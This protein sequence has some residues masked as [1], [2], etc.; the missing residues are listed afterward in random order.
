MMEIEHFCNPNNKDHPKFENVADVVL[1]LLDRPRQDGR[2]IPVEM[3]MRDAVAQGVINNETLAYFMAR[4]QLFMLK[5]GVKREK[6]RFRQHKSNEMA[7]YAQDC[8][9]AEIQSSYGWIECVG[10]ADRSAYDLEVHTKASKRDLSARE[11]FKTPQIVNRPAAKFNNKAVKKT[12]G[13]TQGP[14]RKFF[15]TAT[16]EDLE[17]LMKQQQ[18]NGVAV[19]TVPSGETYELTPDLVSIT[20]EQKKITGIKYIPSVIEP[21]FGLGRIMYS[22]LEHAYTERKGK[23]QKGSDKAESYL[24]LAPAVAPV[25]A[26][27]LT[28][29]PKPIFTPLIAGLTEE[30]AEA[31]LTYR[32]DNSG[33]S[34][35]RKYARADEIGTPYAIV[36]D[37]QTPKDNKVTIRDRDSTS[38]VRVTL[39]RSVEL[40]RALCRGKTTWEEVYATEEQ[41]GR[42]E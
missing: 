34:L 23:T 16:N 4:T 2:D 25:K 32:V 3:N 24:A 35:G 8:W 31:S 38:Q 30:L 13:K 39:T 28:Q 7:H 21:S 12:F 1:S 26:A 15:K 10:H 33:V 5:I 18:E 11:D 42:P 27:V 41:F 29:S 6:L 14:L 37:L 40:V 19:L 22:V 20:M 36:L 17:G 9:D